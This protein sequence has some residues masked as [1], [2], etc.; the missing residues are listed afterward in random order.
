LEIMKN[1]FEMRVMDPP[2]LARYV[3]DPKVLA[4]CKALGKRVAETLMSKA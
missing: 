2:L 4:D 3:P 1:N